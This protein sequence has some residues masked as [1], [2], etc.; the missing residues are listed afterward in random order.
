MTR[1]CPWTH[2]ISRAICL[3]AMVLILMLLAA[4]LAG[5]PLALHGR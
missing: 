3:V 4:I 1:Q 5:V 2:R